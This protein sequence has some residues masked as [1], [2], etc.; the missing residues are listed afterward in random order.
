MTQANVLVE[1]RGPVAWLTLNRANS[2]NALSVDL[3]GEL[4]AAIREIAVAKQVRAIV[5]TAAGRAFCAGA[6]LKE[7]LAG[8]DDADTQK[9]DFLDAIGA[10]FQALR[11]LPKPVIGGLNGIT[12][13]GGL[14]LAMCCDVLIAGESAR[15]GDAHSN[16]GVF[17]GA[18]GAAVL[19]CRIGLANAKYLLFSGQSL[20]ARE[21]MRMGLVQEVV[22]R[23]HALERALELA[24]AMSGYPQ[25][26]L[27]NDRRA[28]IEG[29]SLSLPEGIELE[30]RVHAAR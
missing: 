26:S 10:T 17:P 2:L 5:L 23:G 8:L 1:Y 14:E 15:I 9:G 6:N 29:L 13:A 20:P 11:D 7:V 27:R 18:G 28:V 21:L 4:R 16:F 30:R 3:I 24:K 22:P 12:V 25:V 19:P